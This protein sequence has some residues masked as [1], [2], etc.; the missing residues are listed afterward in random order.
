MD[1]GHYLKSVFL[2]ELE[3]VVENLQAIHIV[4]LGIRGV[5]VVGFRI[6]AARPLIEQLR[7]YRHTYQIKPVVGDTIY[8]AAKIAVPQTIE[9]I[10][11]RIVAEPVHACQPDL[12][13]VLVEYFVA[14]GM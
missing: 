12:L 1:I 14:I 9:R 8:R 5:I 4:E 10:R 13:A 7:G 11:S 3:E 2:G 6:L